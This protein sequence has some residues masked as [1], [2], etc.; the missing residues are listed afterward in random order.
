MIDCGRR[1]A[2]CSASSTACR[3]SSE[4][5]KSQLKNLNSSYVQRYWLDGAGG[6]AAR[7]LKEHHVYHRL[8]GLDV[9]LDLF[10]CPLGVGGGE[11]VAEGDV[12]IDENLLRREV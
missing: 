3:P 10:D 7:L 5:Q 1:R 6:G 11:V 9:P 12:R 4:N 8:G 2:A